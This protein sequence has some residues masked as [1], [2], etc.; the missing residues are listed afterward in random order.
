MFTDQEVI[1]IYL[2]G[3]L[4]GRFQQKAI[5]QYVRQHW[6]AWFP[7]LPSYQVFNH[8]LNLLEEVWPLL[9]DEL[10]QQLGTPLSTGGT[11][12]LIDSLPIMLAVRSRSC[13]AKVARDQA[14]KGYCESKDLSYHG[15]KLHLLGAKQYQ[16]FPFPLGLCWTAASRHDLPPLRD[17]VWSPLPGTLFGDKAYRDQTTS[18]WLA[19]QGTQLCTPDKKEKGQTVYPF[20]HSGLWS[21]FVSAMQQPVESFF[22]WLLVKTDIENG[23]TVRSSEGLKVH[24]YGKLTAAFYLLCFYP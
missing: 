10:W 7:H 19:A 23:S 21:R 9:L 24:C 14:D 6:R 2:F 17:A 22:N 11:D 12:Q 1:T 18:A 20:G 4:Q 16:A 8:R 15:V 13:Q 3:H 5:Y